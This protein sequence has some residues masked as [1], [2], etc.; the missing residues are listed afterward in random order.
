MLYLLLYPLHHD[1][2]FLNLFR[3]TSFRMVMA[4]LTSLVFALWLFPRVIKGL[5][6]IGTQPIREDGVAHHIESKAKTP[7][8]GVIFRTAMFWSC[9]L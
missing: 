1:Y 2:G 9:S 5:A 7:T 6:K 8:A 3:Y 4:A